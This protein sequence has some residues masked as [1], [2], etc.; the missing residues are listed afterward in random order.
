[1]EKLKTADKVRVMEY[2]IDAALKKDGVQALQVVDA[3][4]MIV[5]EFQ[6]EGDQQEVVIKETE[7]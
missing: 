5:M 6:K 1:M 7:K 2:L 3:A 4:R